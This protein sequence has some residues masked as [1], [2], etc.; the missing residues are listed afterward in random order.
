M[1]PVSQEGVFFLLFALYER[2]SE[3]TKGSSL[4]LFSLEWGL[5]SVRKRERSHIMQWTLIP[6]VHRSQGSEEE[7]EKV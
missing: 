3:V 6:T 4:S 2:G 7:D 5:H 1:L